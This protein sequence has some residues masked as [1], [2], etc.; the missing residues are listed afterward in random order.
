[1]GSAYSMATKACAVLVEEW[2]NKKQ[3]EPPIALVLEAGCQYSSELMRHLEEYERP[4]GSLNNFRPIAFGTRA[5]FP[6]LQAAD[7]LA[8]EQGKYLTECFKQNRAVEPVSSPCQNPLFCGTIVWA[9]LTV[10]SDD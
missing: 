10:V 3:A 9:N 2:M 5:S 8:Y 6:G 1:M 4:V 7:L